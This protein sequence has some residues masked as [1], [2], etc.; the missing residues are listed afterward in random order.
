MSENEKSIKEF[1]LLYSKLFNSNNIESS[2]DYSL[3]IA[4]CSIELCNMYFKGNKYVKQWSLCGIFRML[5]IIG[6]CDN[7]YNLFNLIVSKL[8]QISIIKEIDI[9][10]NDENKKKKIPIKFASFINEW[11]ISY[12]SEKVI[13]NIK[14][15]FNDD[16]IKQNKLICIFFF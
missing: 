6:L 7:N 10:I 13:R 8:N 9:K 12:K 16:I 3:K 11:L 15:I 2:K 5:S 14:K 1:K 4:E